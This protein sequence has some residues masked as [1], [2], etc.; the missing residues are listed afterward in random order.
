MPELFPQFVLLVCTFSS[1]Y[2]QGEKLLFHL[3]SLCCLLL[4]F[5]LPRPA[6]SGGG[7]REQ[8]A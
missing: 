2:S 4:A 7:C 8:A 6:S 1:L 3:F 5:V